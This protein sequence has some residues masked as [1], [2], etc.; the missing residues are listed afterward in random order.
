V[1]LFSAESVACIRQP[2]AH[3]SCHPGGSRPEKKVRR[4]AVQPGADGVLVLR[5]PSRERFRDYLCLL[6]RLHLDGRLRGKLDPSDVVQET[7]LKA[8]QHRDQLRGQLV[9][10][11]AVATA[12]AVLAERRT[13]AE[14]TSRRD[15]ER[16]EER[17]RKAKALAVLKADDEEKARKVAEKQKDRA[18]RLA[19]AGQLALA[20]SAWDSNKVALA[21]HHLDAAR[22]DLRGWEHRHLYTR[23]TSNQRTF[24]GHTGFVSGGAFSPDGQRLASASSDK[25][26]RVWDAARGQP[27]LTLQG[28]TGFVFSVAFSP[29]GQRL[30]SASHDRTVRVW[31]KTQPDPLPAKQRPAP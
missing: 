16:E 14:E 21:W 17:A 9:A 29:D 26:V 5:K 7:M 4:G 12:F 10:G 3:N 6:A 18:K 27:V 11:A 1:V 30:A 13:R 31:L 20:Q 15:A 19:Y 8:H 24:L 2:K 28:H 22:W 25:T 23:F